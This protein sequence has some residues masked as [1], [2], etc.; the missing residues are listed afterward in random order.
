MRFIVPVPSI[1]ARPNRK[2]FG[3]KR[4]VTWLNMLSDQAVG[5][6]AKVVSGAAPRDSL[7]MIDVAFS[8]DQ[9]QRPEVLV[10]DTGSYSD[11]VFG[12][13][14]LLGIEYRP[15]PADL[16]DQRTW[17]I[18]RDADYGPLNTAARGLIDLDRIRRHWPEHP[19][20][21]RVDL[22]RRCARVPYDII[23]MLQR[24]GKPTPLGEAIQSYGRIFKSLHI[25]AYLD[26]EAYRRDIKA[27]RNLQEGRHSLARRVFHGKHGELYQ[28][29]HTGME[30]QLG[31]LGLVL[32]C[33]VLWNTVYMNAALEQLRARG[34]H[35][36][37]EDIA[38]LSPF[39]RG[40]LRV[41][42]DY[43]FLLPHLAGALRELRD[44]NSPRL[45]ARRGGRRRR[46]LKARTP[47]CGRSDNRPLSRT[48][49]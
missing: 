40:H 21:D 15:E 45:R 28:R 26:D 24:D 5:L 25:L 39:V 36:L 42:G 19:A 7:H 23:R 49:A 11:L 16:P 35:V 46:E 14:S 8:Q 10:A 30:D 22:H 43:S 18:D 34:H 2:Y 20:G 4:G 3:P 37:D 33:I 12:L 9:G 44:P 1:Y 6:A 13:A 47:P 31:A 41:H 17:R 48:S 32:N 29:Y 38:R 27:I